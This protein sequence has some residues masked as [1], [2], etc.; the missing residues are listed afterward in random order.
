VFFTLLFMT[1]LG[2]WTWHYIVASDYGWLTEDQ[3]SKIQSI[4]FSG[5]LGAIVSGILP[6]Q[7]AK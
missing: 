7:L 2:T 4:I 1:T 6:R 3:L 5:S